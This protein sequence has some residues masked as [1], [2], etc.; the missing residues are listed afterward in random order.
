MLISPTAAGLQKV[1]DICVQY[2]NVNH[3][4]ING[5]KSSVIKFIKSVT[6]SINLAEISLNG[7]TLSCQENI[8]HLGVVL[9]VLGRDQVAVDARKRMFFGAVNSAVARMG[10]SCLSE[11]IRKK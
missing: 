10:G 4:K 1:M 8:N 7:T 11:S 2:A 3:L 9:D 6:P 5:K